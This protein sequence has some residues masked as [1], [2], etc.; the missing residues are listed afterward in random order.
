[1]SAVPR[2]ESVLAPPFRKCLG[3]T[4]TNGRDHET[5][6]PA[7]RLRSKTQSAHLLPTSDARN[8]SRETSAAVGRELFSTERSKSLGRDATIGSSLEAGNE[9]QSESWNTTSEAEEN[10]HWLSWRDCNGFVNPDAV[11]FMTLAKKERRPLTCCPN[12]L[13]TPF[14]GREEGHI[15][16]IPPDVV[17]SGRI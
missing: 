13:R 6:T 3:E 9:G 15:P 4:E 16:R 14:T 11:E 7:T 10:F 2:R 5:K 17:D 8:E 1:M 12:I